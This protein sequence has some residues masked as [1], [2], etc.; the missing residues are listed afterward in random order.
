MY[1]KL[2]TI[3]ALLNL[4]AVAPMQAQNFSR[5]SFGMGGGV[6]T[7]LNPTGQY[8]GVSGNFATDIGYNID[9][10][11]TIF[12]Q[13][14][15]NGLPPN[16]FVLH[17]IKAPFGSVNLYS[18]T[19]NYRHHI[20]SIKG[21]PFGAYGTIGGG[22]YYRYANIDKNYVV[23][24]LTACLPIYTWWGY[25]CDASGYVYSET[26]AY[27]GNSAGGV[28]GGAGFTIRFGDSNWK[29][30]TE[31]RY[32]YAWSSRIRTTLIPVTFG[33]RFN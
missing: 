2:L 15:W 33:I 12:G 3:F 30:Y 26:V 17:P 13:F 23:P 19:A 5:L 18:L 16:L 27:K 21:S 6:S 8:V 31:S 32:I 11:N 1:R 10:K 4:A 25:A 9:K 7:P 29:F 28:N 20:D 24:P 14:M 22:W